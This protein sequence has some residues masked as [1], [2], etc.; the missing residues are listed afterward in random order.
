MAF[1]LGKP[2][3]V[4]GAVA[5]VCGAWIGF[6]PGDHVMAELTVWVFDD[7]HRRTYAGLAERHPKRVRV[8]LIATR[9]LDVRLLSL[10]LSGSR[11]VPDV[12]EL[13]ISS[14]AKY[15]RPPVGEVG[16]LPLNDFLARSGWADKLVRARLTPYS[17]EGVIF[18]VPHDVHPV[19]ITY[20]HDLF[21]EAGIDLP[22]M[23]TWPEFRAACLRF[24]AYWR[25]R[26]VAYRHA[27]ELAESSPDQL[28]PLL[29]QRHLNPI[30]RHGQVQMT[31]DEFIETVAFYAECVAGPTRI[32][33]QSS[34]AA[35]GLARDVAEGNICA[36]LTPDWKVDRIKQYAPGMAGRMRMMPLPVFAPG[37]A[38]TSTW[39][40]TMM[41]IPRNC[42]DPEASWR[43]IE[44]LYFSREG[45]EARRHYSTILPPV[46]TLWNDPFYQRP[47]PYFGGQQVDR[48]YIELAKELPERH[49]TPATSMA[50][51]Y[52]SKVIVDAK[53][54]VEAHP[55][56]HEGLVRACRGWLGQVVVDLKR[57]VEHARFE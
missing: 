52:L 41:G 56:D 35:G 38:R 24:Q 53:G 17:K 8:E 25:S 18:G 7:G 30:D 14:M 33:S 34:A 50:Y 6:R 29:L 11:D 45:I 10:F 42:G 46:T 47:D 37:D 23:R 9:L 49:M 13:E 32:S 1:H 19:S 26:G 15:L 27:L 16:L 12:V 22:A 3:L 21:T 43:L 5:L 20:R 54:Y 55:G 2:I 39:G 57:R 48:L 4:M 31:R 51:A 40:G 44:H 28:I 36:F